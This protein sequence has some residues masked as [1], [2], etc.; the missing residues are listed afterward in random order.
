[1]NK[2]TSAIYSLTS[3]PLFFA[4]VTPVITPMRAFKHILFVAA[5]IAA[6]CLSYTTWAN[7][8][9]IASLKFA[10]SVQ[11]S[12]INTLE[13]DL[14]RLTNRINAAK[15]KRQESVSDELLSKKKLLAEKIIEIKKNQTQQET[16]NGAVVYTA[17]QLD[18]KG[19]PR[20]LEPTQVRPVI[21]PEL[22][23]GAD[24]HV[25]LSFIIDQLG[26]VHQISVVGSSNHGYDESA[27]NA[28]T[29][30]TFAPGTKNGAPVNVRYIMPFSFVTGN[31]AKDS[32]WFS[33]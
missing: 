8:H 10:I 30:W 16:W 3:F 27:I 24:G 32:Y 17:R 9:K 23:K 2:K 21:P 26:K 5:S 6:I 7:S 15:T 11:E 22:R 20:P 19:Q 28:L 31:A 18:P 12:E 33:P 1:M 13:A 25:R 14:F 4:S 29:Q